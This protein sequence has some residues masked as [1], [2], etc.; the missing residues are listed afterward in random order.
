M[1][2]WVLQSSL[3]AKTEGGFFFALLYIVLQVMA[4]DTTASTLEEKVSFM[5]K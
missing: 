1:P 3:E 4:K 2:I 5:Y